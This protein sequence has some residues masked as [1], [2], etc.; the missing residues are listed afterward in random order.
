MELL[1]SVPVF[2]SMWRKAP[3]SFSHPGYVAITWATLATTGTYLLPAIWI[4]LLSSQWSVKLERWV[5]IP[6]NSV[7][8]KLNILQT[9]KGI[10]FKVCLN[11]APH[12]W[13]CNTSSEKI[14]VWLWDFFFLLSRYEIHHA[15]IAGVAKLYESLSI[16]ISDHNILNV[17][18]LLL[19]HCLAFGIQ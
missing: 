14:S 15:L 3:E 9:N 7:E 19:F 11:A 12:L 8:V 16:S 1:L 18:V 10:T 4:K 2:F 17:M 6:L 5:Q 13:R